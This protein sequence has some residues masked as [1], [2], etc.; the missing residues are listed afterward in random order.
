MDYSSCDK[1]A[2][3][4]FG[5]LRVALTQIACASSVLLYYQIEMSRSL[6]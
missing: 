2:A 6:V 1:E 4:I 3:D 5:Q